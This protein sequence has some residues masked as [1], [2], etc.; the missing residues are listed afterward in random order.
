M[1]NIDDEAKKRI[2]EKIAL[3]EAQSNS[4]LVCL[5][6]KRSARYVFFPLLMA[7]IAALFFPALQPLADT[8]GYPDFAITY[9][10]Q[11]FCF[12]S[13]PQVLCSL[14]LVTCLRQN[15]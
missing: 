5:I 13:L 12:W 15:G 7:A 9:Q 1:N 4:E 3:I 2:R 6:T 14:R 11:Q 8:F 10:H